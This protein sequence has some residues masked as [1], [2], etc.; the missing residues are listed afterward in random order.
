MARVAVVLFNLG[1]PDSPGA[2]R[3]FLFNLFNDPAII[4]LPGIARWPLAQLISRRR[5]PVAR[6]IYA[7]LGGKSPLLE[8]TEAQAAALKTALHGD[9]EVEV[10]VCMRYW[11]PMSDAAAAAVKAFDPDEIVLLPLYPQFSTTT[12][13]SSLKGW[14]RAA[15]RAGLDAP[16]HRV[17][18]Y[19]DDAGWIA[20][21]A[22][23]I[24]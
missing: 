12:S 20:A 9:D 2:V 1:G 10:F 13:A 23:L 18:C 8:L 21:Q 19:P 16:T 6:E 4:G 11:H 7:H 24:A 5:A 14:D 3:P 22:A 15:R 17:C